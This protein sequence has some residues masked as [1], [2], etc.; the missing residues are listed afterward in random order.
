V[1]GLIFNLLL[2]WPVIIEELHEALVL[3]SAWKRG[4][5]RRAILWMLFTLA[6]TVFQRT[7]TFAMQFSCTL[8]VKITV[9]N[10]RILS[11]CSQGRQICCLFPRLIPFFPNCFAFTESNNDMR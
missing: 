1:A 7:V 6:L 2:H 5:S 3:C 4:S 8:S 11:Y 10:W 9:T